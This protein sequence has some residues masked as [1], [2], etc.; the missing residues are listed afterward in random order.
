MKISK[1]TFKNAEESKKFFKNYDPR[2]SHGKYRFDFGI[3][4]NA[5]L[6]YINGKL[7]G[8]QRINHDY[9]YICNYYYL[10]KLLAHKNT[11]Y[12]N[13]PWYCLV[14]FKD[15]MSIFFREKDTTEIFNSLE[16]L[17]DKF[18]SFSYTVLDTI[19]KQIPT[20]IHS[21]DF[22]APIK[23]YGSEFYVNVIIDSS[24]IYFND[25]QD[26]F[27][28]LGDNNIYLPSP[29]Y[30]IYW[31]KN[32]RYNQKSF[33]KMINSGNKILYNAPKIIRSK[34][35]SDMRITYLGGN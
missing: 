19:Y 18:T 17:Y 25:H 23:L 29:Y 12:F 1:Y 22:W 34:Q 3:C 32:H 20:N 33:I 13:K 11:A 30:W 2:L 15:N 4:Q 14:M 24:K 10:G 5:N 16:N 31:D 27:Y 6:S 21:H 7:H 35:F 8:W 26:P 28:H 9:K